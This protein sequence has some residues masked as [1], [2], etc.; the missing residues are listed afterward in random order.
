MP[1]SCRAQPPY[2]MHREESLTQQ[3]A[4]ADRPAVAETLRAIEGGTFWYRAEGV[5]GAAVQTARALARRAEPEAAWRAL[6]AS[7]HAWTPGSADHIAPVGLLADPYLGPVLTPERG[8][9]LLST[10][11]GPGATGPA[12]QPLGA[13]PADGLGWLADES[14]HGFRIVLIADVELSEVPRLLGVDDTTAVQPA[15]TVG[16]AWQAQPGGEPWEARTVVRFGAAGE[17]WVFAHC[18]RGTDATQERFHSPAA[19]ASRGTRA[20]TVTYEAAGR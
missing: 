14:R 1:L 11:R 20:V 2:G 5:F 8:R 12:P 10:P 13:A 7:V 15:L 6:A 16:E 9:L 19:Q 3:Y 18:S 4:E 17:G